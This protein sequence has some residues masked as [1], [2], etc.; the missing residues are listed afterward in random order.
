MCESQPINTPI[1]IKS[2]KSAAPDIP[3]ELLAEL[4]VEDINQLMQNQGNFLTR[5]E[6]AQAAVESQLEAMKEQFPNRKVGLV[7]FNNEVVLYLDGESLPMTVAGDKLT[8][9]DTLLDIGKKASVSKPISESY[10]KL[11]D[12]LWS[13]S[14][15]GATALGPAL[16]VS[17]G[18]ASRKPGSSVII[19]T[20]G[21]ANI[22]VGSFEND[23]DLERIA[24]FYENVGSF[25]KEHGVIVSVISIKGSDC[26][27][28]Y[29][30]SVASATGGEV[31]I[32][33]PLNLSQNFNSILKNPVVATNVRLELVFSKYLTLKNDYIFDKD[34]C[35][36]KKEEEIENR[37]IKN[38][39]NA[40]KDTEIG[41]IFAIKDQIP[42]EV[43]SIPFQASVYYTALNK[44]K[45]LR[46][47]TQE[48][49]ITSSE[50]LEDLNNID[51]AVYSAVTGQVSASL[52]QQGRYQE[53]LSNATNNHTFLQNVVH[54]EEQKVLLDQYSEQ[55]E[56]TNNILQNQISLDSRM[57]VHANHYQN[58]IDDT[59]VELYSLKKAQANACSI[60]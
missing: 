20:D 49:V 40:T 12:K 15:S 19:V 42:P 44:N 48:K 1:Q 14:E 36:E 37:F 17:I 8:S 2:K 30:G 46:V 9:F 53:A 60:M 47:I 33:D 43:T 24:K 51:V 16:T 58:R 25:A 59:A 5:L 13:I 52:A 4:G 27:M 34:D 45:Y 3:P 50:A 11:S 41:I 7:T 55:L 39:G 22:G 38:I 21:R 32:V 10:A 28:E 57:G 29:L 26:R 31:N 23:D 6:G 35:A 56:H 18:I 54:S